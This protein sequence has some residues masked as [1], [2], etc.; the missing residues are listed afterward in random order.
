MFLLVLQ[1][2]KEPVT[3][4]FLPTTHNLLPTTYPVTGLRLVQEP[5]VQ[6]LQVPGLT[7]LIR[8][9]PATFILQEEP[10]FSAKVLTLIT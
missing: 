8:I 10:F 7:F 3:I 2:F 5:Q 1:P 4:M 9:D 6:L